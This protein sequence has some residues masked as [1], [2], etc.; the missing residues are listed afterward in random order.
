M[1]GTKVNHKP[2]E[3][4]RYM[5]L[6]N[7]DVI[8]FGEKVTR[9]DGMQQ[10]HCCSSEVCQHADVS[11]TDTHDAITVTFHRVA[12]EDSH[13]LGHSQL[14]SGITF[15]VPVASEDGDSDGPNYDE[16]DIISDDEDE[17]QN[18]SS[19][20]TTPEQS[21]LQIGSQEN[22][23]EL[24]SVRTGVIDLT[25]EEDARPSHPIDNLSSRPSG[26]AEGS[27]PISLDGLLPPRTE[28]PDRIR[29]FDSNKIVEDFVDKDN[30]FYESYQPRILAD[31]AKK[32]SHNTTMANGNN[33]SVHQLGLSGVLGTN[34]EDG[35]SSFSSDSDVSE[36]P[37][38]FDA[39]D[40]GNESNE[41]DLIDDEDEDE[42]HEDED[43]FDAD[44][45]Y[46]PDTY[47][48][49]KE[50]SP[51][52]GSDTGFIGT[53]SPAP[54]KLSS[55]TGFESG[56]KHVS[57]QQLSTSQPSP[58]NR[59]AFEAPFDPIR[60]ATHSFQHAGLGPWNTGSF[61]HD[62]RA[63]PPA[64]FIRSP[65]AHFRN[66]SAL[67]FLPPPPPPPAPSAF[68]IP[69][70]P[71][72]SSRPYFGPYGMNGPHSIPPRPQAPPPPPPSAFDFNAY[73]PSR[74]PYGGAP[75]KGSPFSHGFSHVGQQAM[76][77]SKL[78]SQKLNEGDKK[79]IS[80]GELIEDENMVFPEDWV[81]MKGSPATGTK[82]KADEISGGNDKQVQDA[83]SLFAL[84]FANRPADDAIQVPAAVNPGA[85]QPAITEALAD[86]SPR[87][88]RV[89]AEDDVSTAVDGDTAETKEPQAARPSG[90]AAGAFAKMAGSAVLGGV[91][92][93]AF[94]C[95]PLAEKALEY[96]A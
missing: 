38:A 1:H 80:I 79:K 91:A 77:E 18:S 83:D 21:K 46:D 51:E 43:D 9:G 86:P 25:N 63:P 19:A 78:E 73:R 26:R 6:R 94:L 62:F 72:P 2:L 96:L 32:S 69:P 66:A 56:P 47:D 4:G 76:S 84:T 33:P 7:G 10:A 15:E 16:I 22:P 54:E 71:A 57:P 67:G 65:P 40:E 35:S 23:I 87:R 20:K 45:L 3:K 93:M 89:S 50:P 13:T 61:F 31:L 85:I 59:P 95:S 82:R 68:P 53:S 81:S 36:V 12:D 64:S 44:S 52:L 27:A 48:P 34:D 37:E 58:L 88:R 24:E 55:S 92:T 42:I 8:Q 11:E 30:S 5:A 49:R 28:K 75:P 39:E 70:P 74:L 14:K 90:S 60:P 41:E 17:P 29:I